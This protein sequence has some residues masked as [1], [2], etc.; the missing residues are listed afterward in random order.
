MI[1]KGMTGL[2]EGEKNKRAVIGELTGREGWDFQHKSHC[3]RSVD[4][5]SSLMEASLQTAR[6]LFFENLVR[7]SHGDTIASCLYSMS[8]WSLLSCYDLFVGEKIPPKTWFS[9]CML[10]FNNMKKGEML[11]LF[12]NF[13]I[14]LF[15]KYTV[16]ASYDANS[17][18]NWNVS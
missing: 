11:W 3:C 18:H 4:S 8:C 1:V 10:Q 13:Y 2:V 14:N 5:P 6:L 17:A 7:H 9:V 15:A 12:K 16:N